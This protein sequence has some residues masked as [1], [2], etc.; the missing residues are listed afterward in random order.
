[1]KELRLHAPTVSKNNA[2][3]DTAN[4]VNS[5]GLFN[6]IAEYI[7]EVEQSWKIVDHFIHRVGY[8]VIQREERI[9]EVYNNLK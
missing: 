6:V 9:P 2:F 1:M 7:T 5:A 3:H 4:F 8:T